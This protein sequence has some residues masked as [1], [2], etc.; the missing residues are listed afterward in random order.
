MPI[1]D[2]WLNVFRLS[3][4]DPIQ[5]PDADLRATHELFGGSGP[6]S[7]LSTTIDNVLEVMDK[8]GVERGLLTASLGGIPRPGSVRLGSAAFGVKA[9][10]RAP[11]RFRMVLQLQDVSSP[12]DA[13]RL[14][15]E[16]GALDEVAAI[17]IFPGH[18]GCDITDRRLYP[19]YSACIDHGLPVR[20]NVGIAGPLVPSKHQHPALLEEL[21]IEFPQ[22][23]VIACHMGHPWEDLMIRLIMKFPN[24]YL[25]TSG[26]LPKYFDPGLVKFM[27]S[28]RGAGRVLFGSDHPGIPLPRALDEAR[29]LPITDAALGQFLGAALCDL[30]GWK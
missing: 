3:E 23:T 26:Y 9:C 15:R 24:L 29:K 16:H 20:I 27:G 30:L 21:L 11:E 5:D 7:W 6:Q 22:L 17:G 18:L 12:H 13:A 19:L 14:V 4:A 2:G 28:S 8:T 1:T 10:R 25:M